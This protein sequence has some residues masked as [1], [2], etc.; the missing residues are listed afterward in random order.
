VRLRLP[1]APSTYREHRP[2]APERVSLLLRT[3]LRG[4]TAQARAGYP[5]E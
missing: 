4:Q 5:A 3:G 2:T 1:L